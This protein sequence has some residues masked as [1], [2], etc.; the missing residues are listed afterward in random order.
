MESQIELRP[1]DDLG[2][3]GIAPLYASANAPLVSR[4]RP[5]W[6]IFPAKAPRR[7]LRR[8]KCP[9]RWRCAWQLTNCS[10]G[11]RS[12]TWPVGDHDHMTDLGCGLARALRKVAARTIPPPM[13]VPT[14]MPT[15][16]L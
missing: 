3:E 8:R 6:R 5:L 1:A 13:P 4:S 16:S 12:C 7:V 14:K 11:R 15:M 2:D 9:V 10:P